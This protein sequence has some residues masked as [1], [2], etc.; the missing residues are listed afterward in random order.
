MKNVPAKSFH[1]KVVFDL[2]VS[3]SKS[4]ECAKLLLDAGADVNCRNAKDNTPLMVA[5]ALGHHNVLRL[6]I[7]QSNIDIN[8]QVMNVCALA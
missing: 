1:P 3:Y 5:A 8:A 6:L 4:L 7:S 2:F